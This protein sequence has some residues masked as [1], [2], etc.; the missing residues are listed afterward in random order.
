MSPDKLG[1][2][3]YYNICT[4]LDGTN[5]IGSTEGII[6]H[7]RQAMLVCQC[8]HC[9]NIRNIRIG[10]SQGLQKHRLGIRTNSCLDFSLIMNVHKGG[11]DS[12]KL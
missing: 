12:V 6:N 5:Q 11:L 9:I 3:M 2:G 10:I 7:N 1:C 8:G 4:M